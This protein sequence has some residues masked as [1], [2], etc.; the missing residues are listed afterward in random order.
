LEVSYL[1]YEAE[2]KWKQNLEK[3]TYFK[4][5]LYTA[6]SSQ[7]SII[8]HTI[9]EIISHNHYWKHDW[10]TWEKEIFRCNIQYS[11]EALTKFLTS[12]RHLET[13]IPF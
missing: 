12:C 4:S 2:L 5:Y 6:I 13:C 9:T 8:L 11:L 7:I 1:R 10:L 3:C